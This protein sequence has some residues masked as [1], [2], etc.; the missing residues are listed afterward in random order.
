[1]GFHELSLLFH[2]S[3]GNML[4]VT[5]KKV[6]LCF[7]KSDTSVSQWIGVYLESTSSWGL[8]SCPRA[9]CIV[10]GPTLVFPL[11]LMGKVGKGILCSLLF[12]LTIPVN[13]RHNDARETALG[14]KSGLLQTFTV[15]FLRAVHHFI[16]LPKS[17]PHSPL[18]CLYSGSLTCMDCIKGLPW[19]IISF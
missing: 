17:T 2:P 12:P 14:S 6:H 4:S 8:M 13:C 10:L 7:T 9:G 15:L 11:W 19:L 3:E 16:P 18:S 5:L 1:M